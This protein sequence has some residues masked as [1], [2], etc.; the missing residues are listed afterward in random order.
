MIKIAIVGTGGI[1]E[2]HAS[3]FKNHKD[4]EV[5]AACDVNDDRLN[6]F[7]NKFQIEKRYNSVDELLENNEIDAVTNTTPEAFHKE[8]SI[9]AIKKISIFFAKNLLQKILKMQN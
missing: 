4:S 5:I 7:C 8:I 3:A 9:K 2:W 6:E 1:A